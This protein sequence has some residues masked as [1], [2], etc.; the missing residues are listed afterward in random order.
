M[1]AICAAQSGQYTKKVNTSGAAKAK[2]APRCTFVPS[3]CQQ[4]YFA[5]N[6]RNSILTMPQNAQN[7]LNRTDLKELPAIC[8]VVRSSEHFALEMSAKIAS[9]GMTD[10]HDSKS[11]RTASL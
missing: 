2:L 3:A 6:V 8:V 1:S 10:A 11:L 5:P 7:V 4:P 9:I